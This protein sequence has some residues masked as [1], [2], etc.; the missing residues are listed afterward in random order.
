MSLLLL[1]AGLSA[2]ALAADGAELLV[3]G[4]HVPGLKPADSAAAADKM[5]AAL[6]ATGKADALPPIEVSRRIAGRETLILDTYALGVG[7]DRLRKGRVLYE[8]AQPDQAIP[9]LDEAVKLL[10]AGLSVSTDARD[11]HEALMVLG[12]SYVGMGNE[13]AARRTFRRSA[14]L[15]PTRELNEVSYPPDVVALFNEARTEAQ[16]EEPAEIS[17][18]ASRDAQV[19]I[20]GRNIGKTP[21]VYVKLPPG[22]HYVLVRDDLGNSV[23]ETFTASSGDAR[24]LDATLDERSLG[25]AAAEPAAR[26]RQTRDLYRAVGQYVGTT[27]VVV[28]GSTGTGQVAVQLYSPASGSF[29]RAL[30]GE[31]GDDPVAA[32]V[33]LV[34]TL[35]S[36]L[37]DTGDIR[38]DRVGSQILSLDVG[39]N[40][41][42]SG[43]LLDPPDPEKLVVEVQKGPRWYVW[44]GAGALVAGGGVTA[45]ALILNQPG[46]AVDPNQGTIEFGPIP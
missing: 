43:L 3:V 18:T 26:S 7:R 23:F 13:E 8:G 36:Y 19:W 46:A 34:P 31:A 38:A 44:A 10:T 9:E 5:A 2:S 41:V 33:D 17:V 28:A 25:D 24:K 42:L 29:S 22:E 20:D 16:A 27:A 15:D 21:Q 6:D 35:A 39:S 45:A 14:V 30:T 11:V 40:D 32:L 1:I 37:S 12:M 4:V